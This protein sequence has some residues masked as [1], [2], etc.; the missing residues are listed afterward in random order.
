MTAMET[1]STFGK[2]LFLALTIVVSGFAMACAHPPKPPAEP[3]EREHLG[4]RA[5]QFDDPEGHFRQ[6]V[7]GTREGADLGYGQPGGG[8]GCN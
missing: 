7:F 2:R 3:W 5:M 1:S 4:K 8:C 6:H